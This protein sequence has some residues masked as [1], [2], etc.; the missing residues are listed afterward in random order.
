M[1]ERE[2][3]VIVSHNIGEN[4]SPTG[5]KSI[6]IETIG[7]AARLLAEV[8]VLK[9]VNMHNVLTFAGDEVVICVCGVEVPMPEGAEPEGRRR[10]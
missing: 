8:L 2:K 10:D 7:R 4:S 6:T 5:S 3:L 9:G 1:T